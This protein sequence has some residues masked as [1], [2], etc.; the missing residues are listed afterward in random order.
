MKGADMQCSSSSEQGEIGVGWCL[1]EISIEKATL[2]VLEQEG[3][4]IGGSGMSKVLEL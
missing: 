2:G 4:G 1:L 3:G